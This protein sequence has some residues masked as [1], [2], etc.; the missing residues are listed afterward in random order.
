MIKYTLPEKSDEAE[1][2][3]SNNEDN[4]DYGKSNDHPWFHSGFR[5]YQIHIPLNLDKDDN[6]D[7]GKSYDHPWFHSSF[8][9]YQIHIPLNLNKDD[10]Q[11]NG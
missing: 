7:Y 10:N 8:R 6:Q 11:N 9:G 4:Q 1:S 5:G 3:K 2:K